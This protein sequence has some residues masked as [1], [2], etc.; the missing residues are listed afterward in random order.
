MMPYG[1]KSISWNH[2]PLEKDMLVVGGNAF[3]DRYIS[4]PKE[5]IPNCK[6]LSIWML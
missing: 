3:I 6:T 2:A 5:E 1:L 4:T